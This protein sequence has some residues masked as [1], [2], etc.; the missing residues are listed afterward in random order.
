MRTFLVNAWYTVEMIVVLTG[1]I[2][3]VAYQFDWN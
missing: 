3:Y 1:A 2:V